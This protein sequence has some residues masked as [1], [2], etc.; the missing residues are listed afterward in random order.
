[1]AMADPATTASWRSYKTAIPYKV[2]AREVFTVPHV[3]RA[4]SVESELNTRTPWTVLGLV[5]ASASRNPVRMDCPN[6]L[7]KS[8]KNWHWGDSNPRPLRYNSE[9]CTAARLFGHDF[10]GLLGNEVPH[11]LRLAHVTANEATTAPMPDQP[12]TTTTTTTT[13]TINTATMMP[14]P[15]TTTTTTTPTPTTTTT[16][17]TTTRPPQPRPCP[18]T[19][20]THPHHQ[21]HSDNNNNNN[22]NG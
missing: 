2:A 19:M 11:R 9:T 13:I 14:T 8:R 1:M 6:Y 18:T 15:T 3:F 17:T 22:N 12:T 16:T 21:Q 7:I 5:Q 10:L 4:E 20:M